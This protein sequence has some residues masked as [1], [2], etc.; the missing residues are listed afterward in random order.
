MRWRDAPS[1]RLGC[2]AEGVV[3]FLGNRRDPAVWATRL[4]SAAAFRARIPSASACRWVRARRRWDSASDR[5]SAS[6]R[7]SRELLQNTDQLPV[8]GIGCVAE[9]VGRVRVGK[10]AQAQ[11]LAEA[12]PPIEPQ[13]GRTAIIIQDGLCP[14]VRS[15]G[16]RT[17]PRGH[18]DDGRRPYSY[19]WPPCR[20]VWASS[21]QRF[22]S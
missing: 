13:L 22:R 10:P 7:Q 19:F 11:E 2:D 15:P 6:W 3:G 18:G 9:L 12:L 8:R 1:K 20:K 17:S 21:C 16:R 4:P 5:S 14:D